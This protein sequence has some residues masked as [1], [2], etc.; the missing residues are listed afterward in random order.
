MQCQAAYEADKQERFKEA[1]EE[2]RR[3]EDLQRRREAAKERARLKA[4][5]TEAETAAESKDGEDDLLSSFFSEISSEKPQ[6]NTPKKV[7]AEKVAEKVQ[8][9]SENEII[10]HEK[11]SNQDLGSGT[12]QVKRLTAPNYQFKNLNPYVVLQLDI[13]ATDEDIKNR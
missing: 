1:E 5:Q 9:V 13:D 7:A 12:D 4:L 2:R 3:E 6:T 10:F 11:Y 8:E